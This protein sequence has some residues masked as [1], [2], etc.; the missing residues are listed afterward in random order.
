MNNLPL[1]GVFGWNEIL[2][3]SMIDFKTSMFCGI[4]LGVWPLF[5]VK[6]MIILEEF[7]SQTY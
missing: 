5:G 2:A 7:P 1:F 4:G 6:L 3:P